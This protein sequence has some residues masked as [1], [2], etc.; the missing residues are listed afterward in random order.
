MRISLAR[1]ST[2]LVSMQV[3]TMST[4]LSFIWPTS[5]LKSVAPKERLL[6]RKTIF[7]VG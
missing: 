4:P 2:A 5:T 6:V 3:I 1:F 7:A